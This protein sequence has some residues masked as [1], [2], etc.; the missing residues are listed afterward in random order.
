[1]R[2]LKA[3]VLIQTRY[4]KD[5]V[6]STLHATRPHVSDL[7]FVPNSRGNKAAAIDS[8]KIQAHIST[9]HHDLA[10]SQL[11]VIVKVVTRHEPGLGSVNTEQAAAS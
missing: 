4:S 9:I 1:M 5:S 8:R 7:G 2:R 3:V 10:P 11:H 6:N